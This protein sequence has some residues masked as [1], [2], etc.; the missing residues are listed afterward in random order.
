MEIWAC[1]VF[2]WGVY[3]RSAVECKTGPEETESEVENK[4]IKKVNRGRTKDRKN[5]TYTGK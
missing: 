2:D 5:F 3:K 1:Y 4:K